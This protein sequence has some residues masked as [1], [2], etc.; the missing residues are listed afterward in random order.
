MRREQCTD[1]LSHHV[2]VGGHKILELARARP[3]RGNKGV[4]CRWK[5]SFCLRE[6]SI[7]LHDR[8]LGGRDPTLR[9]SEGCL[10]R[11]DRRLT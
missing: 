10:A 11:V 3:V 6:L 4:V 9:L 5:R 8:C 2:L 1:V 7:G